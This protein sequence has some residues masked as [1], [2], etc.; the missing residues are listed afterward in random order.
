MNFDSCT[1]NDP[2]YVELVLDSDGTTNNDDLKVESLFKVQ[3]N[4][5]KDEID[6]A[7]EQCGLMISMSEDLVLNVLRRH[8]CD[9][10]PIYTFFNWV[11][12]QE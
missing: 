7:L 10:K 8:R 5:P 6:R 4:K 2:E 12:K 9:W 1:T 11:S 3:V